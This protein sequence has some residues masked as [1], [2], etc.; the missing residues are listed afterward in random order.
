M[1]GRVAYI[2]IR[3]TAPSSRELPDEL[4][5]RVKR[6]H[7]GFFDCLVEDPLDCKFAFPYGG[8]IF[9]LSPEREVIETRTLEGGERWPE[10]R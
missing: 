8:K 9:C 5:C 4:I 3:M 7:E 2:A 1:P 10:P 6:S